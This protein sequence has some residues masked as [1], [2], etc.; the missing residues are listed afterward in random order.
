M[1]EGGWSEGHFILLG[2]IASFCASH[3]PAPFQVLSL[4]GEIV[5][6]SKAPHSKCGVPLPVPWV[7]IPPSP[8]ILIVSV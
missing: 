6:G 3:L 7:R 2:A 5:E 8:P 4:V 1:P